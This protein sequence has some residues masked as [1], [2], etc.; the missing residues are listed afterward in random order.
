ML[1]GTECT[2]GLSHL[3]SPE[4]FVQKLVTSPKQRGKRAREG[5]RV[6]GLLL[7]NFHP[8]ISYKKAKNIKQHIKKLK[9]L[10]CLYLGIKS[11][12]GKCGWD[13]ISKDRIYANKSPKTTDFQPKNCAEQFCQI[14]CT[15]ETCL[16][17]TAIPDSF[18]VYFLKV[19]NSANPSGSPI[20]FC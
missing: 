19:Q 8:L 14:W 9:I 18:V 10:F 12:K 20:V 2:L 6:C 13:L 15:S 5:V 7:S 4:W 11:D 17:L 3:P 1:T 16:L